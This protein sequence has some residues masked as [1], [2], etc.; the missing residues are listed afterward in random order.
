MLCIY[1]IDILGIWNIRHLA[2]NIIQSYSMTESE[3]HVPTT[4]TIPRKNP[5]DLYTWLCKH[6][7][8]KLSIKALR[9]S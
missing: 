9:Q 5:T 3:T 7:A 2:S 6:E 8:S 1:C 4:T